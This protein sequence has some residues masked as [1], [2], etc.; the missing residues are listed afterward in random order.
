M[1]RLGSISLVAGV[2]LLAIV[3][4]AALASADRGRGGNNFKAELE[5]FQEV[6]AISSPGSGEFRAEISRDESSVDWELSYEGLQ[7]PTTTA[8]HIHIGQE[9][10][11]GAVIVFLCGGGG[12][13]PCTP[14]NGRFSGTFT[15]SDVMA[16]PAQGIAAGELD[17]LLKAM[18]EGVTYTNVH[19]VG[20]LG[21]NFP[22][23][24]IRGQIGH[25]QGHG[26]GR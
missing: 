18:R 19:T 1:K 8:A 3:C 4:I 17:E 9:G 11:N 10:V 25:G 14:T 24:E 5:G 26:R 16:A 20:P 2:A 21:S 12:R 22:G 15:A 7:G 13:P 6:P 23:G